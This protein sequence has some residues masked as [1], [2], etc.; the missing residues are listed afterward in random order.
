MYRMENVGRK[1][2]NEIE[3]Y[4]SFPENCYRDLSEVRKIWGDREELGSKYEK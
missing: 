4:Y 1:M 2:T 3:Q